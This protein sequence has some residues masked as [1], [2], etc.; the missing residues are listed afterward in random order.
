MSKS[1]Q[2]FKIFNKLIN[3]RTTRILL[4]QENGLVELKILDDSPNTMNLLLMH[5]TN[6]RIVDVNAE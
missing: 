1:K 4:A 2:E 3:H 5:A 6:G